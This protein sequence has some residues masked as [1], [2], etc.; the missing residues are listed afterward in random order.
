[1]LTMKE[2]DYVNRPINKVPFPGR[3]YALEAAEKLIKAFELYKSDYQDKEY[4]IIMSNGKSLTFEILKKNLCHMLGID[5]K[6][7]N[8][9]FKEKSQNFGGGTLPTRRLMT[10]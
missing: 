1:M 8:S 6:L 5:Y 10:Y 4:D 7:V 9:L 3:N 2:L